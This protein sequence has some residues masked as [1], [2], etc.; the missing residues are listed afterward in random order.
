MPEMCMA[1]NL[2]ANQRIADQVHPLFFLPKREKY[3]VRPYVHIQCDTCIVAS[4]FG[5]PLWIEVGINFY[6]VGKASY[7]FE[8]S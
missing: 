5:G 4:Q 1:L 7:E 2:L 6:E 3:H 8:P